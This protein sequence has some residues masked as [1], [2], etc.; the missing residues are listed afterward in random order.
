[1]CRRCSRPRDYLSD[2]ARIFDWAHTHACSPHGIFWIL[3]QPKAL[4]RYL[5]RVGCMRR[6]TGHALSLPS[7][8]GE[9]GIHASGLLSGGEAHLVYTWLLKLEKCLL[10]YM[11]T[12][13]PGNASRHLRLPVRCFHMHLICCWHSHHRMTAADLQ[14]VIKHQNTASEGGHSSIIT[15]LAA[16]MHTRSNAVLQ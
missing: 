16:V 5:P 6:D 15:G 3:G 10:T 7:G 1:M 14:S 11:F 8:S 4:S 9:A 13:C 12:A 2:A